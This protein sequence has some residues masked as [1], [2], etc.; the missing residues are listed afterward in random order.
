MHVKLNGVDVQFKGNVS[1]ADLL[2]QECGEDRFFAVA[3]NES[4]V[5]RSQ[6][7]EILLCEG[8]RIEIVV[9]MQGG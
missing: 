2:D 1:L 7:S 5:P 4:F 6:Y 3:I 9:P 8:D